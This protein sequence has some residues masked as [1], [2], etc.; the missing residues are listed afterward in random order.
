MPNS[1]KDFYKK[2][3]GGIGEKQAVKF[4]KG[5]GYKIL[6]KNYKRATGEIDVIAKD[7]EFTVFV[8]V[9][10]RSSNVCGMPSEAVD[11]KKQEKYHKTAQYYLLEKGLIDTPCRFDVVEI[12]D[13]QINHINNA[14][15]M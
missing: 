9:K 3:L 12:L 11:R 4:L 15:C 2:L 10:T 7:G 5:L 13:G 8:E 1:Q 6:E 14:F